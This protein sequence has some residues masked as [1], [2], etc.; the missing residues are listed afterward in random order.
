MARYSSEL[1]IDAREV[2]RDQVSLFLRQAIQITP[3]KTL[4]Q[5]RKAAAKD[6]N[7]AVSPLTEDDFKS[8]SIK[9]LIRNRDKVGLEVV[10]PKIR[11]G[12]SLVAF[13]PDL[14]TGARNKGGHVGRT[15]KR[16]T[17]DYAQWKKYVALVQKRVG[18]MKAAWLPALRAVGG[19]YN[20]SWVVRHQSPSGFYDNNLAKNNPSFTAY[21]A[22][23]G[24]KSLARIFQA[25]L[26]IR[27]KKMANDLKIKLRYRAEKLR[28][29]Q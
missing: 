14:H 28:L 2:V 27:A 6:I 3:P 24:I 7:R 26:R 12:W 9:R 16:A 19:T 13:S 4:A 10:L 1:G 5:G 20:K 29:S 17:L 25:A 22:A 21:N 8:E 18:R 11:K 23:K 15:F